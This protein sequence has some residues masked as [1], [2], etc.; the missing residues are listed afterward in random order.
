[1]KIVCQCPNAV[2][3][4]AYLPYQFLYPLFQSYGKW[5]VCLS[6][7]VSWFLRY[8]KMAL[9]LVPLLALKQWPLFLYCLTQFLA[10]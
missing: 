5:Y 9:L 7:K 6:L 1:M 8:L 2:L 10:P 3:L 4:S